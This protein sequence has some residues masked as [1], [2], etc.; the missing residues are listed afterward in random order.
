MKRITYHTSDERESYI[1][2]VPPDEK[3]WDWVKNTP[4]GDIHIIEDSF[5]PDHHKYDGKI[6]VAC[7][8]ESPAIYDYCVAGHP[9]VFHPYQWIKDNH[10]HFQ[11]VMSPFTFLKDLVGDRYWWVPAGGNRI[12][13]EDFGMWEKERLVSIVAS[14]KQWTTGHK[15][16]H[17]IVQKYPDK[18]DKYGSGYN[19]IVNHYEGTRL[20][21]ILAIAPYYYS[22]AIM[23]S[24]YDDYFTE[25]LTDV[26]AVG[27]IPIWWGTANY[28]KYFNPDG[29]VTFNTMEELDA[30]LPTLTP[31]LYKSKIAAVQENVEKAKAYNTRF[32]WVYANYK[33]KLEAL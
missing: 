5:L 6:K 9:H 16:R 14:H 30:L 29:F 12:R 26:L 2:V 4:D 24:Q 33:A 10:Q 17:Q 22:F 11:I 19:D 21:K 3:V 23:N 28:G 8:M 1:E 27:T 25:I 18:I 15:L 32:E 31:E 20:G 13:H 7:L